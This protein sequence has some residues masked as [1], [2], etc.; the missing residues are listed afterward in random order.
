MVAKKQYIETKIEYRKK[1]VIKKYNL[2]FFMVL[3][4]IAL[5]STLILLSDTMRPG[6]YA[7]IPFLPLTFI[8]MSSILPLIYQY[9]FK[10]I[11]I[12]LLLLGYFFKMVILPMVIMLGNYQSLIR[13]INVY[14]NMDKA[15]LL[16]SYEFICVFLMMTLS[17]GKLNIQEKFSD[18]KVL[19]IN[20]TSKA[21][22]LIIGT[23]VLFEGSCHLLYPQFKYYTSFFIKVSESEKIAHSILMSSIKETVPSVIYWIYIFIFNILQIIVP[24]LILQWIK[25]RCVKK[26]RERLG[27]LISVIIVGIVGLT[28]TS[29]KAN[30]I[31]AAIALLVFM[32]YIYPKKAKILVGFMIIAGGITVFGGLI[33]K[34][35]IN[36]SVNQGEYES[37]SGMLQS[38]FNGPANVATA[39]AMQQFEGMKIFISDLGNNTP[40]LGFLFNH[41][42]TSA[43]NFNYTL[44]G[45]WNQADQ[46]IPIIGQGYYYFG[47][48]FA[49]VF[50]VVI[51][52]IA[53][54]ME[55]NYLC[56]KEIDKKYIYIY[57]SIL[58]SITPI[59]YNFSIFISLSLSIVFPLIVLARLSN[60]GIKK[61]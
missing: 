32:C 55:R 2:L 36:V 54:K 50:S 42:P 52:W 40:F 6:E 20:N 61:R 10:Y 45:T 1:N 25:N 60:Y 18:N 27:V 43:K 30:S 13:N 38:Y 33:I 12:T 44:Y 17:A 3:N 57:V 4:L 15:I 7:L 31:L 28:M 9:I 49:P 19:F 39:L 11:S 29:E 51:G 46:I 58:C 22:K 56:S 47:I 14:I 24:M 53:I 35:G 37:L 26:N 5:I 8:I 34:S 48:I 16:M 59:I 41:L 23:L 21:F